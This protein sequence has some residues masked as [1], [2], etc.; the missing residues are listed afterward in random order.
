MGTIHEVSFVG[1]L[2]RTPVVDDDREREKSGQ[3]AR[4]VKLK[5]VPPNI[6]YVVLI[7]IMPQAAVCAENPYC[8]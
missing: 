1:G 4:G 6:Q 5:I 8:R 3:G 2:T 7:Q